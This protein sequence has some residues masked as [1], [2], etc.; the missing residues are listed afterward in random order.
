MTLEKVSLKSKEF[1]E[2]KKVIT[3]RGYQCLKRMKSS[4]ELIK[5]NSNV[6]K[7][8]ILANQSMFD[9]IRLLKLYQVLEKID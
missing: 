5:K 2:T 9:Q 4:C 1:T 7:A 6:R 8:F 3:D